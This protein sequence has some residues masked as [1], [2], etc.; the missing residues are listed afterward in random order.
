MVFL[1]LAALVDDWLEVLGG[2]FDSAIH[3]R[4]QPVESAGRKRRH[5]V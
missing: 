5:D 2:F 4:N 3:G 1:R